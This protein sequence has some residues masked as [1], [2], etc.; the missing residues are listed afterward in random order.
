MKEQKIQ[1]NVNGRSVEVAVK[2]NMTLADV[3]RSE[4]RL[5]GTKKGCERGNCGACTVIMNGKAV[6]SC[7]VL[8][9][10]AKEADITTIEGLGS[11]TNLHPL[12]QA[13][14]D[15]GAIQC[16]FCIPGMLMSAKA[17]LDENPKP[18]RE[19]VKKGIAGNLC[20]C[21]GYTRQIDAILDAAEK[22]S[23]IRGE[24]PRS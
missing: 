4:L 12:Q 7:L 22:L 15:H 1:F 8:A 21:T 13:F 20:R 16:G 17:L 9:P 3:I 2:P 10:R 18:T 11:P 19:E 5:T 23:T 14:I 6:L 24:P